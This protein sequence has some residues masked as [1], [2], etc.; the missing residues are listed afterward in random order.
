MRG[1]SIRRECK[2][3]GCSVPTR[4]WLRGIDQFGTRVGD[5]PGPGVSFT[6]LAVETVVC[7]VRM[8]GS[9]RINDNFEVAVNLVLGS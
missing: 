5:L 4:S 3:K 7:G 8:I 2:W 6:L 9:R 1:S